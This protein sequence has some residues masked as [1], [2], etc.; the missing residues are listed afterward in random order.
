MEILRKIWKNF[1]T[2]PDVWFFFGFLLTFTLS[3][4]KVLFYFP[5]QGTFNE[6]AGIYIYVSDIFLMM[7]VVLWLFIILFNIYSNLSSSRLWITCLA[8][9]LSTKSRRFFSNPALYIPAVIILWAFLSII[10]SSNKPIAFFRSLKLLEFYLLYLYIIFRI[11]PR[12]PA[13]RQVEQPKECST[14]APLSQIV[15]RGT[16]WDFTGWNIL[17]LIIMIIAL[18][19]SVIGITQVIFQHSIG[20]LWLKESLI[21]P[22]IPGVAKV[23]INGEKYIR[24]YGLFPHPNILGGFLLFSII[25]TLLYLQLFHVEQFTPHPLSYR[26]VPRGTFRVVLYAFLT[27]QLLALVLTLSKSA[28]LGLTIALLYI[29]VPRLPRGMFHVEHFLRGGTFC[30]FSRWN[31]PKTRIAALGFMIV[32]MFLV[33]TVHLDLN[34]IFIQSLEERMLYL[35][36][37]RGTILANPIAGVGQGQF[38]ID[39]QKFAPKPLESWQFQPVHNVYLIIWSELGIIGLALF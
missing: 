17:S 15:P 19:Q 35:N 26:N 14:P 10:W 31:N 4:R 12:L 23:I 18:F 32:V 20:L 38:V 30:H 29:Y 34:S 25:L 21:S 8:N 1:K 5:I 13:S 7:A 27:V 36:V 16:I 37:S 24:A 39:M 33:L 9:S 22:N 11:V 3:V 28:I 2:Q 6:Y